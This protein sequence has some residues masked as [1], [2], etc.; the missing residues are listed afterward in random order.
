VQICAMVA[1]FV[2]METEMVQ[3]RRD[4]GRCFVEKRSHHLVPGGGAMDQFPY[5]MVVEM[6]MH[7]YHFRLAV[8][9][10]SVDHRNYSLHA[11]RMLHVNN[12]FLPFYRTYQMKRIIFY[13]ILE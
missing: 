9:H 5:M 7:P 8:V 12:L 13:T 11:S 1:T 10:T 4:A 2:V 3:E 6:V